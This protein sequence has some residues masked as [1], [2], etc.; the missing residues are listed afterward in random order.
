MRWSSGP[1]NVVE[2]ERHTTY[3]FPKKG[4]GGMLTVVFM[5]SI[6]KRFLHTLVGGQG[7]RDD[8][9]DYIRQHIPLRPPLNRCE[10][11]ACLNSWVHT[12]CNGANCSPSAKC[13]VH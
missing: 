2:A 9:M 6:L 10:A 1:V 13:Y 11:R 3:V 8:A 4:T 5:E 7:L 12:N